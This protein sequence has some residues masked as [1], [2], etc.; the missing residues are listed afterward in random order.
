MMKRFYSL[1]VIGIIG[2]CM[3]AYADEYNN[4][5]IKSVTNATKSS[6]KYKNCDVYI[7]NGTA[8]SIK[9]SAQVQ[10]ETGYHEQ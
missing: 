5:T 1:L 2:V 8:T 7:W 4:G 9:V 10:K 6:E 3:M